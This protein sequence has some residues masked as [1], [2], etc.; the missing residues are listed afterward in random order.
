MET[1]SN[2]FAGLFVNWDATTTILTLVGAGVWE[3]LGR[4]RDLLI[5]IRSS[6]TNI[7]HNTYT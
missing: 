5:E 2:F 4:I 6:L 7:D 1:I 3:G